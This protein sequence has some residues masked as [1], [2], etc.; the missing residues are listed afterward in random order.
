MPTV[1]GRSEVLQPMPDLEPS[2][3][4]YLMVAAQMHADGRLF[5]DRASATKEAIKSGEFDPQGR[6]YTRF[7]AQAEPAKVAQ[8][9]K[10]PPQPK[11]IEAKPKQAPSEP[12]RVTVT[13]P[14]QRAAFA[15]D[16]EPLPNE[17]TDPKKAKRRID[18]A[19]GRYRR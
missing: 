17:Y 15:P 10:E 6:N 8:P 19:L 18:E 2:P 13:K 3:I 9:T 1:P 4:A 5:E 12:T 7:E 16:P 11:P 14:A